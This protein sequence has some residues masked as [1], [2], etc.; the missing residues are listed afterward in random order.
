MRD[1]KDIFKAVKKAGFTKGDIL[2]K[3]RKQP[4]ALVRQIAMWL[5]RE[6]RTLEELGDIF[7]RNHA[8]CLHSVKSIEGKLS[9]N[10][11]DVTELMEKMEVSQ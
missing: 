9:Y 4:L 7:K 6:G 3:N 10:D 8:A 5:A 2:S 1:L 11:L